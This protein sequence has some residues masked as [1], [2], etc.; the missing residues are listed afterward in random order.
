MKN[1]LFPTPLFAL[2]GVLAIQSSVSAQIISNELYVSA[3]VV[4]DNVSVYFVHGKNDNRPVPLALSEA[5]ARGLA[6]VHLSS[7]NEVVVDNFSDEEVFVQAGDLLVGGLQDQVA[8]VSLIV[9]PRSTETAIEVFCVERGRS[10]ARAERDGATFSPVGSIIPSDV[11]RLSMAI[12]S[13]Q[14]IAAKRIRQFGVWLGIESLRARLTD[15]IGEPVASDH[16]PSS[17]PMALEN[18]VLVEKMR[19][20]LEALQAAPDADSD[21]LGAIFALNGRWI[22]AE[23]YSSNAFFKEMWPKLIRAQA[24]RG[25]ASRSM[26]YDTSPLGDGA[27]MLPKVDKRQDGSAVHSS[28]IA[29]SGLPATALEW[30]ILTSAE[31]PRLDG[32]QATKVDAVLLGALFQKAYDYDRKQFKQTIKQALGAGLFDSSLALQHAVERAVAT[33]A[34]H[35][36]FELRQIADRFDADA[37]ASDFA[38]RLRA[39]QAAFIEAQRIERAARTYDIDAAIRGALLSVTIILSVGALSFV[40]FIVKRVFASWRVRYVRWC[41]ATAQVITRRRGPLSTCSYAG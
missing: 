2:M 4:H 40:F 21:I 38:V 18:P 3:P 11:A 36:P 22:S 37:V 27:M 31:A 10:V 29:Q 34:L 28:Y 23:I 7:S 30:A 33:G 19:P 39:A 13:S 25:I 41:L 1:G 26:A 14:T 24:I 5:V 35:D 16:S 17:L 15:Q 6:L 9:P 20:Y 8:G 12:G 32:I